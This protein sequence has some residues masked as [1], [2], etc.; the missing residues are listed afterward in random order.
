MISRADI[1]SMLGPLDDAI[2]AEIIGTG[3]STE[4]LAQALAWI[5]NDEALMNAGKP[6]PA[7]RVGALVEIIGELEAEEEALA[8]KRS[9]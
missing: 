9:R 8:S 5:C 4:E 6:L 7:G 1:A 3:A 2:A